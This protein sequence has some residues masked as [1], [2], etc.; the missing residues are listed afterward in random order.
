MAAEGLPEWTHCRDCGSLVY[1]RAL[2]RNLEVCP[3]C[4][5]HRRVPADRRLRQLL[6]PGSHH[7]LPHAEPDPLGSDPL[8]FVDTVPYPRRLAAA[9]ERTG[10]P[11][12]ALAATGT[13]HGRPVVAVAMDFR[14][15]GGSLGAG[16]G[17]TVE[18]AADHALATRTP[19]LIVT[20]SGG[21][22]MQEGVVALMQMARTANALAALDEAGVLTVALIT[23]PTYGGV[24][25]SY[26]SLCDVL[27]A[28]P[29]ARMGFA[30]PRVIQQTLRAELPDGFQTAESLLAHGLIDAI[31]PRPAVRATLA[32][33]LALSGPPTAGAG[34]DPGGA[35]VRSPTLLPDLDPWATVRAA[36]D[37][38]R[39]TVDEY[40]AG[41]VTDFEEL[42]G[43][44]AGA[45]SAAVLGGTGLLDGLPVVLI[46]HRKGHDPQELA[47]HDFGM[48]GPDG[49]RK[50]ARMMR[51]ADKLRLPVITLVDTPGAHPGV[52][53]EERGQAVAIAENL[54]L[55][56]KLTVPVV[57]VVTGEGG[58]GGALALAV[59]DRVLIAEQ[60]V[61]SVISPEGC[62]AILWHDAD[63]ASRAAEA[64]RLTPPELLRLGVVDAVIRE[65]DGGAAA[66]PAEFVDTLRRVVAAELRSLRAAGVTDRRA[67]R[68]D[69]FRRFDRV[70]ALE[71][72]R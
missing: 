54:S 25:A 17:R 24:A 66:R 11:E 5:R 9:R 16:V 35:V 71:P 55:M 48:A 60:A 29:G 64:L 65:P 41:M 50:A 18:R 6:D 45:D 20:A 28:E 52:D 49:Y 34:D 12:A 26:A 36:R 1:R 13:V 15:L 39:P 61:Y 63:M 22:R 33:L 37:L 38:R 46:G 32:R 21:A 10:L 42:H 44:R 43:D 57:T 51:L 23:D 3:T 47:A 14:F 72:A 4:G 40:V 70:P 69:R 62:A 59:A 56:G 30:G 2:S 19:L 67:A 53:A 58:S 8:G 27:V 7:P 68:R 31:R